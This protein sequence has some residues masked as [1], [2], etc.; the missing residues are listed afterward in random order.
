M[1]DSEPGPLKPVRTTEEARI[2]VG[3]ALAL[4]ELASQVLDRVLPPEA[5]FSAGD[6]ELFR[7]LQ[8][9]ETARGW[10]V[11]HGAG[12]SVDHPGASSALGDGQ[13]IYEW[14]EEETERQFQSA[15]EDWSER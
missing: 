15:L 13:R 14:S 8:A 2:R 4:I 9:A 5:A 11:G 1:T 3:T 12:D 7:Y 6:R 10:L